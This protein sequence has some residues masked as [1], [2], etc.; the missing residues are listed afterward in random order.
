MTGRPDLVIFDCDGVLVNSERI[1]ARVIAEDLTSHGLRMTE[2]EAFDLF[3]GGTMDGVSK[4]ARARGAEMPDD[5][6]DKIYAKM[7]DALA[8]DVEAV[9]GVT[10]A[11]DAVEAAGIDTCIGSNGPMEKMK[12]TL[13]RAGLWDRFEGRIFSAH[14][15]GIAKPDPGLY[16]HAARALGAAPE[17]CVVVE[18]SATGARAAARAGMR[19]LGYAVEAGPAALEAEGAEPFMDMAALPGLIGL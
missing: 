1:I 15:V 10:A 14:V 6:T 12:I 13:G 2:R 17:S 18:D 3:I 5:W 19:C 8:R 7:F 4:I 9:P 11:V 16:L